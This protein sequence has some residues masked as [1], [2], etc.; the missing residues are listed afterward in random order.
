MEW[1]NRAAQFNYY[2]DKLLD[3][4]KMKEPFMKLPHLQQEVARELALEMLSDERT[5]S[6]IANKDLNVLLTVFREVFEKSPLEPQGRVILAKINQ[7]LEV[8]GIL[9]DICKIE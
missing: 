2:F 6:A 4:F 1:D 3:F 5:Q 9:S 8:L 7:I